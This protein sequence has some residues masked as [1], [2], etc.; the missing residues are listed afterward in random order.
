MSRKIQSWPHFAWFYCVASAARGIYTGH[1]ISG[2]AM[3]VLEFHKMTG[4][5]LLVVND[6]TERSIGGGGT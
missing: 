3:C 6:Y 5:P 2:C 4:R 1:K